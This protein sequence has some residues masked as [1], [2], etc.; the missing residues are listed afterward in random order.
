MVCNTAHG[1]FKPIQN[2]LRANA[3]GSEIFH[4]ADG[5]FAAL[6]KDPVLREKTSIKIGLMATTGTQETKL[7]QHRL[8]ERQDDPKF[9]EEFGLEENVRIEFVIPDPIVQ[10][11]KGMGA[12]Y[13]IGKAEVEKLSCPDFVVAPDPAPGGGIKGGQLDIG[14]ERAVDTAKHLKELGAQ[15]ISLS[16]TEYPLVLGKTEAEDVGVTF[17]DATAAGTAYAK[18]KV[19]KA[20]SAADAERRQ[21]VAEAN[22]AAV[23]AQLA[24]H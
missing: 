7:Y 17:I 9:A 24:T 20:N 11:R 12:I 16:C 22:S 2:Y 15:V 3:P 19:E 1:W 13:G 18:R 4:I 23:A 8:K 5:V 21:K 6:G 10:E 14:R